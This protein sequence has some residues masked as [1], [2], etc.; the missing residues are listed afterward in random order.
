MRIGGYEVVREVGRGGMGVVYHARSADGRDVAVKVLDGGA[1]PEALAAFDRERRLLSTLSLAEGFVPVLDAGEERGRHYFVMPL[2]AG[3][4]LRERIRRGPLAVD[5]AVALASKLATALGKAHERGIVHRDVKP[6]NV[7]FDA[8]GGPLVADLGLAKHFRRD[9]LGATQSRNLTGDGAVAG[10]VGY[11]APEQLDDSRSAGPPA[12]VFALGVLLHECLAGALPFAADGI[13]SYARAVSKDPRPLRELVP[14]APAWLEATLARA[15]ARSPGERFADGHALARALARRRAGTEWPLRVKA[16]VALLLLALGAG[17]F[18]AFTKA[19]ARRAFAEGEAALARKDFP[20]A[21]QDF[22]R[23]IE[24][25]PALA[26][27][28]TWRAETRCLLEDWDGAR[29]DASRGAELAPSSAQAHRFRAFASLQLGE[30]DGALADAN[31]AVELDPLLAPAWDVRGQV[32]S[33]KRDLGGALGDFGKAVEL[34]PG[35]A[36]AWAHLAEAR[37]EKNDQAGATQ[38]C[39]RALELDP[40]H[41]PSWLLLGALDLRARRYREAVVAYDKAIALKGQDA[42]AWA[43]RSQ[44]RTM[45]KDWAGAEADGARAVELDPALCDGWIRRGSG[46]LHRS[47]LEG[48]VSDF[49]R[50][51]SLDPNRADAYMDRAEAFSKA[52]DLARALADADRAVELGPTSSDAFTQRA[53]CRL[54]AGDFVG[55]R[56]DA[57]RAIE[58][59]ASFRTP[60]WV[61]ANAELR[62]G[63]RVAALADL[64]EDVALAPEAADSADLRRMIAELEATGVR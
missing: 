41:L 26:R 46:R 18:V 55:A 2:L 42:L 59:D 33:K 37:S 43:N 48:A 3:G 16:L 34:D 22:T 64:K 62:L 31:R 44:A 7:L 30:V 14:S 6:E 4:S 57:D 11:M 36:V 1:L 20:A 61:R 63:D 21:L 40:D 50:A 15:L 19:S 53:I 13:L 23:A 52:G 56:A 32:R 25:D 29:K 9:V 24:H 51:L 17:G 38:A 12:D 49:T 10:T 28:W 5:E 54:K 39:H 47:D 27:A 8:A 60:Y 45:L 35:S 58:L